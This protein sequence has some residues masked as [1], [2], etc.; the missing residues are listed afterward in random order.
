MR[1]KRKVETWDDEAKDSTLG[2]QVKKNN[3]KPLPLSLKHDP[4]ENTV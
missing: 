1:M 3:L 2:N 4:Q